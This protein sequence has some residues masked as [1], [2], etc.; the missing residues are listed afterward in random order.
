MSAIIPFCYE[1]QAFRVIERDGE[2]WF[3]AKDVCRILG[4]S[5]KGSGNTGSLASLGDDEK[6]VVTT[7]TPGGDQEVGVINES[8]LYTLIF[9]SRKPTAVK[10][11]KW[12]TSEVLPAIR[13]TGSYGQAQNPERGNEWEGKYIDALEKMNSIQE[14]LNNVQRE[15]AVGIV[16]DVR[17]VQ[18]QEVAKVMFEHTEATDEEIA[19]RISHLGE[20]YINAEWVAWVRRISN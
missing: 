10:F 5:W 6:G 12:V 4:I 9:R 14:R 7:D 13:R 15:L 2:P 17:F 11:R 20:G 18:A 8:G 16:R 1:D 19:E 3:M